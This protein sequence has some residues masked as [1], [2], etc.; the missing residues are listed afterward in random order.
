MALVRETG[1]DR[2]LAERQ[3]GG[4]ELPAG[5]ID[6]QLTHV[7]P[8]GTL[9]VTTEDPRKVYGMNTNLRCD[10]V[11]GEVLGEASVKELAGAKQPAWR[12]AFQGGK[13]VAGGFGEDF[14]SQPF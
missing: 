7:I 1:R 3:V 4:S 5:E 10:V 12:R 8:R 6:T 9:E 11:K 14:E 13:A 2:N